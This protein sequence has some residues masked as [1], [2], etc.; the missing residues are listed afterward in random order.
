MGGS[1]MYSCCSLGCCFQD[2]FQIA[3]SIFVFWTRRIE[4]SA[5][6]WHHFVWKISWH[7]KRMVI[8]KRSYIVSIVWHKTRSMDAHKGTFT[9]LKTILK[10][11]LT[12]QHSY[13]RVT[14]LSFYF[15]MSS[16]TEWNLVSPLTKCRCFS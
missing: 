3:D 11:C 5:L 10:W 13:A 7:Q 1:W 4:T 2:L 8:V 14:L 15:Q 6:R 16:L 12:F 9:I